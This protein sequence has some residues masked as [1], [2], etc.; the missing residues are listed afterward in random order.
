MRPPSPALASA[1]EKARPCGSLAQVDELGGVRAEGSRAIAA[2]HAGF[3]REHDIYEDKE[4]ESDPIYRDLL[5]PAGLGWCAATVIP[6]RT[7]DVLFLSV[8]R[9]RSA[10]PAGAEV[11]QQVDALRPHLARSALMA[12]RP[13]LERARRRR[14]NG[15]DRIAGARIQRTWQGACRQSFDRGADRPRA[16]AR[17]RRRL[18]ERCASGC[19]VPP[20]YRGALSGRCGGGAFLRRSRR[21]ARSCDG[22]GCDPCPPDG[23]RYLLA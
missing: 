15:A 20:S 7:S 21:A 18:S 17:A 14:H 10:G 5:W 13:Q 6:A 12:A 3:L 4:L 1:P 2:R 8:E 23:L 16:L 19:V 11:I 22:R 9:N